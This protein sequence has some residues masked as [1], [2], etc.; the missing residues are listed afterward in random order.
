MQNKFCVKYFQKPIALYLKKKKIIKVSFN[1]FDKTVATKRAQGPLRNGIQN[2][3]SEK[4]T[5]S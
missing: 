4:M 1:N 2:I 5:A 3:V